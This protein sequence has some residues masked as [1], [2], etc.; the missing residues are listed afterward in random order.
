MDT[1]GVTSINAGPGIAVNS[2]TVNDSTIVSASLAVSDT[3]A[4]GARNFTVTNAGPG[5]GTSASQIFTINN[6]VP[7]ISSVFPTGGARLQAVQV[8]VK[9]SNFIRAV[10]S[11]GLGTYITVDSSTVYRSDSLVAYIRIGGT[12]AIGSRNV[13]VTN[14]GPGGGTATL[15]N[16][17]T[18]FGSVV[19]VPALVNLGNVK[20]GQFK[21]STIAVMNAGNDTLKISNTTSINN[22]FSIR[23]IAATIP[24]SLSSYDTI[25]FTPTAIGP[26]AGNILIYSNSTSSPDT[27]KISAY[28]FGT[29]VFQ[30]DKTTLQFD[31]VKIGAFRDSTL[32]ITNTGNDTLKISNITISNGAFSARPLM[33]NLPPSG[34]FADTIRFSPTVIG[35]VSGNI[36]IFSNVSTS[37][38]TVKVSGYGSGFPKLQ[39][40]S[41]IVF[42][43]VKVGTYRD[44]TVL[45]TNAGNDTLR[46]VS[47]TS[48]ENYFTSWPTAMIIAPGR[49]S[50]DSIRF[51][52]DSSGARSGFIV[53]VSNDPTSPDTI[54]VSGNGTTTGVRR[55]GSDI[56]KSF[57]L[58]QNFPNPFNPSTTISFDLPE[59]SHVT[60]LIY[61]AIGREVQTLADE[62]EPAGA[63]RITF[64][65]SAL[66]SGVYFYRIT[67]GHFVQTKKLMLV[68]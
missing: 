32:A 30:I 53:I 58:L 62:E 25:R 26:S 56:P 33:R 15:T 24:P 54:M 1:N 38:D 65:A 66:P 7:S 23:P 49:D 55:Y 43:D 61:D 20:L 59:R 46:I 19:G 17:F 34:S 29:P 5:G 36:L 11:A 31:T 6:P 47:I 8:A 52:P 14:A 68:K 45:L 39:T 22:V 64:D 57:A 60:L 41:A 63:Y 27:I 44:T 50:V 9:G 12:A 51:T 2:L 4:T 67:A 16:G 28:A 10:T 13:T 21:D 42:G 18:V 48:T 35:D 40:K 3:A 37:P